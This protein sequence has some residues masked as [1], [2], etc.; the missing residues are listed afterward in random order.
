MSKRYTLVL[1]LLLSLFILL[2]VMLSYYSRLATDDYYFIWDV[3]QTGIW[4]SLYLHYMEWSGRF[5]AGL[6]A[7]VFYKYFGI[8]QAYYTFYPLLSLILLVSG[9]YMALSNIAKCF[10]Q[11]VSKLQ[12]LLATLL[13]TAL[14]FF[15]SFD[16]GESWFWY[17]SLCTYLWSII[18]F[19]WGVSAI[20]SRRSNFITYPI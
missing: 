11:I 8:N 2:Y 20:F 4:Q 19:I 6:M 13:F 1:S 10:N 12:I 15:L 16:I 17:C 18:F 3:K 5:S 9:L 14:F 7:D